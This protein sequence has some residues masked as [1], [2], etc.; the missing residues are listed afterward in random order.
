LRPVLRGA[1]PQ[2]DDFN[3][4]DGAKPYLISRLGSYCSYCERRIATILAVEHI[5]PKG[6]PKYAALECVWTNFLLACVNCNSAKGSQDVILADTLLPDRDNTFRAFTYKP[7]GQVEP[8]ATLTVPQSAQAHTLLNLT[9][10]NKPVREFYDENGQLIAMDRTSQRMEA[11]GTAETSLQDWIADPTPGLSRAIVNLAKATGFFSV[12]LT[13][14]DGQPAI[15]QAIINEFPGT[16]TCGCFA[17]PNATH[18]TPHPNADLL[19]S[20]S[21]V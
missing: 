16:A 9:K 11:W 4:Y 12:W 6:L 7:D 5:Q 8:S 20:G 17:P 10:I 15:Q 1:S 18:V 2:V 13:V 14:F 19:A 3:P 21:K